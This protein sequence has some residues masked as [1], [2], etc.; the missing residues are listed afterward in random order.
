MAFNNFGFNGSSPISASVQDNINEALQYQATHSP[1][2][3]LEWFKSK[4]QNHGDWD[5]KQQLGDY[6][7]FGNFNYGADGAA[8][9]YPDCILKSGAG[10]AQLTSSY[11][12]DFKVWAALDFLEGVL[13]RPF[14][15]FGSNDDPIDQAWN[16]TK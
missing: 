7:N 3:T 16:D 4:V 11:G 14:I 1:L 5:Y 15:D 13:F 10:G 12:G 9:G 8:L 2:E 6:E